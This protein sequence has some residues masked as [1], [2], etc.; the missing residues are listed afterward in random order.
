MCSIL[1]QKFTPTQFMAKHD[2]REQVSNVLAGKSQGVEAPPVL[3]KGEEYLASFHMQLGAF[4]LK[5]L[6]PRNQTKT[7]KSAVLFVLAKIIH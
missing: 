6:R 4:T 7:P 5:A 3:R 1:F 2:Q